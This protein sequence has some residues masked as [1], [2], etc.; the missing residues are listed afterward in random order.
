LDAVLLDKAA[1]LGARI[2][3]GE[4]ADRDGGPT[5]LACGRNAPPGSNRLFGFKAHFT[6]P[7]NDAVELY[8]DAFG[9]AGVSCVEE[10]F[11]N[12]CAIAAEST[13]QRFAFDFDSLL[14]TCRPLAD[15]VQPLQR[16]MDWIAVGPLAYRAPT[17]EPEPA[18]YP[19]G[20]ALGFVDPF[21]GSG[22]LNALWTGRQAGIAA[23]RGASSRGYLE[24]C[25]SA[26]ERPYRVSSVLRHLAGRRELHPLLPLVPGS[27]LF[28]LTR[29]HA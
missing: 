9:Y 22:I 13:L 26:L 25:R 3:R 20:D 29:L 8:F 15:R 4:T 28:G 2:D 24:T 27:V 12:V 19:A 7:L 21:T 10:G 11:T 16:A 18:V 6:G 5:V 17:Q 14:Q 1:E 23:A